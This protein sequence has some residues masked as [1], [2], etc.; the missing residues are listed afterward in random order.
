MQ[1]LSALWKSLRC[2]LETNGT[3]QMRLVK[4]MKCLQASDLSIHNSERVNQTLFLTI[5]LSYWLQEIF[6]YSHLKEY[7]YKIKSQHA[8]FFKYVLV[9][10][11]YIY[12]QRLWFKECIE[13]KYIIVFFHLFNKIL[14]HYISL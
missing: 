9:R 10:F 8:K 13:K 2:Q 6:V 1:I 11:T 12:S 5:S 3:N 4:G 7:K 14:N